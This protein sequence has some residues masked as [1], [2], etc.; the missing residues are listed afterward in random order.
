MLLWLT[1]SEQQWQLVELF[2]GKGNVSRHFRS[3]GK[4]VASLDK[5]Y[6]GAAM[7]FTRPAGLASEA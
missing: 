1:P 5:D 4:A 6:D 3:T 2:A 7:D